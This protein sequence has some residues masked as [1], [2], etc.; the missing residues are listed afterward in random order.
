MPPRATPPAPVKMGGGTS[1]GKVEAEKKQETNQFTA[2][3]NGV[4]IFASSAEELA[5]I[6]ARMLLFEE[7]NVEKRERDIL[8]T[9][10]I[11]C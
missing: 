8:K 11:K 5:E 9:L 10:R 7:G 6:Q 4:E 1:H 2:I 3:V